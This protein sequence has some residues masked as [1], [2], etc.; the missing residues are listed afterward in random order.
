MSWAWA[1]KDEKQCHRSGFFLRGWA[2]KVV[3][4]SADAWNLGFFSKSMPHTGHLPGCMLALP[5]HSM[6]HMYA[7]CWAEVAGCSAVEEL[8]QEET[9]ARAVNANAQV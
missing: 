4:L 7:I 8:L 5:S 6:G 9:V 1:D 3:V 2:Y